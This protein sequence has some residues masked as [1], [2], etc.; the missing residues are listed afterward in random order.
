MKDKIRN[1]H[2]FT[3]QSFVLLEQHSHTDTPHI[4]YMPCIRPYFSELFK[5]II[6]SSLE[7]LYLSKSFLWSHDISLTLFKFLKK[8]PLFFFLQCF[9]INQTEKEI[10]VCHIIPYFFNILKDRKKFL[11]LEFNSTLVSLLDETKGSTE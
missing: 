5:L 11:F 3:S 7:F 6:F 4:K 8:R 2:T 9:K 1:M 10:T